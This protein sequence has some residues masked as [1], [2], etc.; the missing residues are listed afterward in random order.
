MTVREQ[1]A[2]Y[3]TV[4]PG[5][6]NTDK[7]DALG[8]L[9]RRPQLLA[10][11]F[12]YETALLAS[13]KMPPRL[14]ALA[15]LKAAA[16]I[17]CE[18]CL[19]IGSTLARAAGVTDTQL[20]ALPRFRDSDA[21]DADEKLVLELADAITSTPALVPD[22]LRERLVDRFTAPAVTELAATVAWENNRGRLNQA[23]GVRPAGFSQGAACAVPERAASPAG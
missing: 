18:F 7:L 14:K 23:L 17:N 10:G 4:V 16:L 21:F 1:I 19:D 20:A 11:T 2:S 6:R 15:E 3:R 22:E 5:M 13:G 9:R 12:A 8:W